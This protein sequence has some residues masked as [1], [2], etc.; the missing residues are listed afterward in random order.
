[1]AQPI[2]LDQPPVLMTQ[3]F[4]RNGPVRLEGRTM[5]T[6]GP[7]YLWLRTTMR[8][9]A[10]PSVAS[11]FSWTTEQWASPRPALTSDYYSV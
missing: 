3:G 4:P 9:P 10:I 1:M 5:E 2:A 8:D 11:D 7:E 6:S